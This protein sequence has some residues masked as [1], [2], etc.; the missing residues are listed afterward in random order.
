MSAGDVYRILTKTGSSAKELGLPSWSIMYR[1]PSEWV[2]HDLPARLSKMPGYAELREDLE[3]LVRS[4][5]L[6]TGR[7]PEPPAT[8]PTMVTASQ[9]ADAL[10]LIHQ[11]RDADPRDPVLQGT[12]HERLGMSKSSLKNWLLS[13]GRPVKAMRLFEK[14]PGFEQ[15]RPRL[16]AMWTSL[17]HADAASAVRGA[18]G[19]DVHRPLLDARGVAK[20]LALMAAD[21]GRSMRSIAVEAGASQTTLRENLENDGSL[22]DPDHIRGL[23]GYRQEFESIRA[24]LRTLGH[25]HQASS[26]PEPARMPASE[27]VNQ[28]HE[29][30]R[31][32]EAIARQLRGDASISL[33]SAARAAQVPE[34]LAE[35][36]LDERGAV[37]TRQELE[38][39]L[40]GL[41][42]AARVRLDRLL[43]RLDAKLEGKAPAAADE[44]AMKDIRLAG[45]GAAPERVLV[46]GS[47]TVDPGADASRRMEKLYAQNTELV[48]EPRSFENDRVHQSMRWLSTALEPLFPRAVEIQCYLVP[49]RDEIVVSSNVTWV[50][51]QIEAFLKRGGLESLLSKKSETA[52]A[53]TRQQRHEQKLARRMGPDADP[54]A[55]TSVDEIRSAIAGRRFVTPR[56]NYI[57]DRRK[58]EVHAERRIK[59]YL[60]EQRLAPIAADRLGGT[61]RPCGTCA[62]EIGAA[63][64]VHR[65][66]VWMSNSARFG[67]DV[68]DVIA[69]NVSAGIGTSIT[70][71]RDGK[72]T[73]EH[74][75]DSDSDVEPADAT[76]S[77][78]RSTAQAF[79]EDPGV[80]DA[81]GAKRPRSVRGQAFAED[82]GVPDA[83]AAKRPRSVRG[84]G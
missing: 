25:D 12:V 57:V 72:L 41:D 21:P 55:G 11:R 40:T 51:A 77:R 32:L 8:R 60:E 61:M 82:P 49:E 38:P 39:W 14:L 48:R 59:D 47:G 81:W 9:L 67:V 62:D 5:G 56:R 45:R 80:P 69:R 7:L 78:K 71:A 13:D 3:V 16:E 42:D 50:N 36:L 68:D 20:A 17:G 29:R 46:L 24:S 75:T 6:F 70:R 54:P 34:S 52:E 44:S 2:R 66:P 23:A 64:E 30:L 83:W 73:F 37:R 65:G 19:D 84:Q 26:L 35:M 63:P 53:A 28:G 22:K 4:M 15:A 79:A 76:A 10:E 58:I 1:Q 43:E 74:D 33:A 27:L 18:G 31:Q